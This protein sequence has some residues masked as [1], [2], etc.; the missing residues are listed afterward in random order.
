LS[1]VLTVTGSAAADDD[2]ADEVKWNGSALSGTTFV[3][4]VADGDSDLEVVNC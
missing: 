1:G 4:E 3:P 2:D